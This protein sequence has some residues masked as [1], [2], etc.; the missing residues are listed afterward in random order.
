M[1]A[2]AY[3]PSTSFADDERNNA[4]GRSTVRTDRVDAELAAAS[5]SINAINDNLDLIQRD[6]GKLRDGIVEPYTLS[7]TTKAY[8]QGSRFNPMGQ[9]AAGVSYAVGDLV[10]KSGASYVA[11][12]A[13][14]SGAFDTDYAAGK[15]QVFVVGGNAATSQFTP[16][17]TISST[18]VQAAI[19]EVDAD[20]RAAAMPILSTLYGGL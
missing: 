10:D 3:N 18:T 6:D 4:G 12:I 11:A 20:S 1:K 5:Q 15:W 17:S 7:T 13:H 9:W 16:T 2:P 19:E 14:T 8:V